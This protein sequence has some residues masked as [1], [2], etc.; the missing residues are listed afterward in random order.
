MQPLTEVMDPLSD[1]LSL[2][3]PHT[4]VAGGFD[5]GGSISI[6]FGPHDGIKCYAVESGQGWLAVEG[7]SEPVRLTAGDCFLLPHGRPFVLATDLSTPPTDFRTLLAFKPRLTDGRL[8]IINGGGECCIVGGHFAFTGSHARIL[9]DILPTVAH[10]RQESDKAAMRWSLERMRQELSDPR[11]GGF[12]VA[13]HLAHMMLVQALRLHLADDSQA[14]P[15][16]RVGWLF[17]LADPQ[18][19]AAI[20]AM[21]SKPAHHW[22]LQ[23]LAEAVGMS[24]SSFAQRFKETVGNSPMEYLAHWRMLVAAD[25]LANTRNSISEIALTLGYESESAFSTA[26]KRTMGCSPRQY[27]R[28]CPPIPAPPN[29]QQPI[30]ELAI[31]LSS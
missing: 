9:L 28:G 25:K 26:F 2:L 15:E 23:E 27:A 17:A 13:Q 29:R 31:A 16:N 22:T 4:Y 10:I 8:A 11:P 30:S 1:V 6:Q 18:I 20:Q 21:H 14:S 19:G 5:V 12:L 7:I 3:K 24:R